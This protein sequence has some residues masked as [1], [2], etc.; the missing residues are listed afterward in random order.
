MT[1]VQCFVTSD[2]EVKYQ[3]LRVVTAPGG[4]CG[5][6]NPG[7]RNLDIFSMKLLSSDAQGSVNRSAHDQI[8]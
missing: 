3:R 7:T 5:L 1:I 8:K 4:V 2:A 6:A